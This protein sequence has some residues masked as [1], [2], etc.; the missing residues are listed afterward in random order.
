MKITQTNTPKDFNKL[1]RAQLHQIWFHDALTDGQ[2]AKK[3]GVTKKDVKDKRKELGI[4]WINGAVLALMGG[5]Q[6]ENDKKIE[7]Q[8]KKLEKQMNKKKKKK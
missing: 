5:K 4:S 2:I 3:F 6:Y 7:R 8:A 1:N